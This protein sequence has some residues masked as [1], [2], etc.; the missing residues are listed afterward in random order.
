MVLLLYLTAFLLFYFVAACGITNAITHLYIF[1]GNIKFNRKV[2]KGNA[3]D[4]KDFAPL[5]EQHSVLC[6]SSLEIK[7][8]LSMKR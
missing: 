1:I 3:E 5:C 4:R 8:Q 7:L 2:H 6:G